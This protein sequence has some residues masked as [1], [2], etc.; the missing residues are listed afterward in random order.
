MR[1]AVARHRSRSRTPPRFRP[2]LVFPTVHVAASS[3]HC[4]T[5]PPS[6][7]GRVAFGAAPR[8]GCAAARLP[9]HPVLRFPS[10]LQNGNVQRVPT[11]LLTMASVSSIRVLIPGASLRDRAT[12][13]S[14][15]PGLVPSG[16]YPS[17]LHSLRSLRGPLARRFASLT[18]ACLAAAA[19]PCSGALVLPPP[20]PPRAGAV[21]RAR[22]RLRLACPCRL[23]RPRPAPRLGAAR[24]AGCHLARPLASPAF[25]FANTVLRAAAPRPVRSRAAA[26]VLRFRFRN[27][28]PRR[29]VPWVGSSL[30]PSVARL[31]HPTQRAAK[32]V[33]A[34]P[35]LPFPTLSPTF[36]VNNA[37]G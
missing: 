27:R 16:G 11:I 12:L 32:R 34:T 25:A 30:H 24:P 19:A 23:R 17:R 9:L 4:A 3:R 35:G 18:A 13:P 7:P 22:Q 15:L 1:G 36:A 14:P 10:F 29:S 6:F 2:A 33:T 8:C 31:S 21:R 26:A 20:S 5:P 37:L 28:S